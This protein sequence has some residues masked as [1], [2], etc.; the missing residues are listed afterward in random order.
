MV[1]VQLFLVVMHM[2][3]QKEKRDAMDVKD[4]RFIYI[5]IGLLLMGAFFGAFGLVWFAYSIPSHKM[6][7]LLF[8]IAA[9]L[10]CGFMYFKSTGKPSYPYRAVCILGFLASLVIASYALLQYQDIDWFVLAFRSIEAVCFIF[11]FA[12]NSGY[13]KPQ[14]QE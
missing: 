3:Q 13:L 8:L 12:I 7:F 4:D 5:A 14:A 10:Y 11:L 9:E 6:T 1:W 2:K